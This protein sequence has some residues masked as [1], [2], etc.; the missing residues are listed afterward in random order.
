MKQ[1]TLTDDTDVLIDDDAYQK[2]AKYTWYPFVASDEQTYQVTKVVR[3]GEE[4]LI[5]I[6]AF[7]HTTCEDIDT[8]LDSVDLDDQPSEL[9]GETCTGKSTK[10]DSFDEVI[11]SR[12]KSPLESAKLIGIKPGRNSRRFISQNSGQ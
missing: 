2:V 6:G 4:I 7:I 3:D 10:L 12:A 9:Y 5:E 8:F 11:R 1:I